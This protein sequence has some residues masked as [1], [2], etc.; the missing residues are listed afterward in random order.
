VPVVCPARWLLGLTHSLFAPVTMAAWDG[1]LVA[2]VWVVLS[3]WLGRRG[4]AVAVMTTL[5]L[6][7]EGQQL[8]WTARGLGLTALLVGL[9]P[10]WRWRQLAWQPPA[11][12]VEVIL[13]VVT[14]CCRRQWGALL[15]VLAPAAEIPST[16]PGITLQ[17]HLSAELLLSLLSPLSPLH[18]GAIVIRQGKVVAAG[19]IV[20]LSTQSLALGLGTRHRAALG[21]TEQ[22]PDGLAI[23]VSEET[24]QVALARRGTLL[25]QLTPQQLR[26]HLERGKNRL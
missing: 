3:L 23:V 4:V 15:V 5:A 25:T 22:Q 6:V 1:F 16:L 2:G 21:V 9:L 26:E 11:S 7:A 20:P 24:G 14:E 8:P 17:A 13:K 19:V 18:D 12:E 10:P